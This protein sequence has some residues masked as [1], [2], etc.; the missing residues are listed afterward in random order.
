MRTGSLMAPVA[1]SIT[2]VIAIRTIIMNPRRL[3]AGTTVLPICTCSM[4]CGTAGTV[5][6]AR[7]SSV[8]CP[9]LPRFWRDL[10]VRRCCSCTRPQ[11]NRVD[12]SFSISPKSWCAVPLT[13]LPSPAAAAVPDGR[14]PLAPAAALQQPARRVCQHPGRRGRARQDHAR[15]PG[16]Q[17]RR[18]AGGAQRAAAHGLS[19]LA[20]GTFAVALK[21]AGVPSCCCIAVLDVGGTQQSEAGGGGSYRCFFAY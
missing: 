1:C 8:A 19:A 4:R 16:R 17:H 2:G 12:S 7:Q 20:A 5:L 14:A 15:L 9:V 11:S 18:A 3:P 10:M 6:V 21:A 13:R